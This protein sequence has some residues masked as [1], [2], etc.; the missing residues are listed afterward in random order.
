MMQGEPWR[1]LIGHILWDSRLCHP[2]SE[3]MHEHDQAMPVCLD[4]VHRKL[5]M[6]GI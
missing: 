2:W 3:Q 5:T 1:P 4:G 6:K